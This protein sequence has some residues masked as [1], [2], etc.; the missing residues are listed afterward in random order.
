MACQWSTA[1]VILPF[2][3]W[4]V[5]IYDTTEAATICV[6]KSRSSTQN[7]LVCKRCSTTS[8]QSRAIWLGCSGLCQSSN[9]FKGPRWC[10]LRATSSNVWLPSEWFFFSFI[11][12][13]NFSCCNL[14]PLSPILILCA[15]E[16]SLY[17]L[18]YTLS[19]GSWSK[20]SFLSLSLYVICSTLLI[21]LVTAHW[22]GLN[23]ACQNRSSTGEPLNILQVWPQKIQRE[24]SLV[25]ICW[26]YSCFQSSSLIPEG[27]W[28]SLPKGDTAGSWP[29]C[30]QDPPEPFLQSFTLSSQPLAFI[31]AQG[32]S[33]ESNAHAFVKGSCQPDSPDS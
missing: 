10:D 18:F 14:C 4:L 29:I 5:Y 32:Y 16:K 13:W 11:Y 3:I 25:W 30:T 17:C 7:H 28:P 12:N 23:S 33:I 2:H 19:L 15:P 20:S 1:W 26:F 24:E 31:F 22:T 27:W 21:I 8:T 9:D 6:K